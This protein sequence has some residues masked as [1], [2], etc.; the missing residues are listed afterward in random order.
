MA[1]V[2]T[3][4][5]CKSG[6]HVGKVPWWCADPVFGCSGP[7]FL[8]I[9]RAGTLSGV[10]TLDGSVPLKNAVAHLYLRDAA[11]LIDKQVTGDDGTFVFTGLDRSKSGY[12]VLVYQSRY[13]SEHNAQ[14]FDRL[15]PV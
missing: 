9:D 15:T 3:I 7:A 2:T 8:S 14:V 5:K 4:S 10:A 1:T 11:V 13:N 6:V 12:F